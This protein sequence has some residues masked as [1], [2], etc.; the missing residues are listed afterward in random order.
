[1][2]SLSLFSFIY[3]GLYLWAA[4]ERAWP[5]PL[6]GTSM[7]DDRYSSEL[8][9]VEE[10]GDVEKIDEELGYPEDHEYYEE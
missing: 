8:E 1:M 5:I 7:N 3:T 6:G 10:I 4:K 9:R 2:K